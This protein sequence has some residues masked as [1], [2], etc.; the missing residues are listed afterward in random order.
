MCEDKMQII[1]ARW[2]NPDTLEFKEYHIITIMGINRIEEVIKDDPQHMYHRKDFVKI[3]HNSGIYFYEGNFN[4]FLDAINDPLEESIKEIRKNVQIISN[5]QAEFLDIVKDRT[6][7]T[8]TTKKT[9][10]K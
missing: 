7:P 4:N 5:S 2:Q 6:K 9:T 10:T 3:W 8:S 1:R